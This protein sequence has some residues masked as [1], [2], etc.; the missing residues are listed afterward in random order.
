M[1]LMMLP[2]MIHLIYLDVAGTDV[3][4]SF[5][6]QSFTLYVILAANPL[7]EVT[8]PLNAVSVF[9]SRQPPQPKPVL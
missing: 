1:L 2:V 7:N 8:L 4:P 5:I 3:A 6:H 9:A